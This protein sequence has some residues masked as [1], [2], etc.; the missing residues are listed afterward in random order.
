[1]PCLAVHLAVAKKYLEHHQEENY[2]DF[3]L[4]SIAPDIDVENINKYIKG[5]SD[6]K[7]NH[8]FGIINTSGNL[9]TYMKDK[10]DFKKFFEV[11][12]INTSFLRAYF[13]HLFCDY[14]FL[15]KCGKEEVKE[16]S[17]NDAV[18]IGV[19]DYDLLATKL[20][21]KYNLPILPQIKDILLRKG[22]GSIQLLDEISIDNVQWS[23]E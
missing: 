15:D 22:E 20:I 14:Y 13:L 10:V 19:N 9:I 5:V 11:N 1:M 17:F 7:A 21:E 12:D 6:D 18:K 4:G 3:I 8:H 16:L 2:D 23:M